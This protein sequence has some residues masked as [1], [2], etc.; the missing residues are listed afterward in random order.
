[1]TLESINADF[2]V[3]QDWLWVLKVWWLRCL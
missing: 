1:M 2:E 3:W